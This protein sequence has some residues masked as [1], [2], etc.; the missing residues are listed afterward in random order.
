M[1]TN[2]LADLLTAGTRQCPRGHGAM[3]KEPGAWAIHQVT[4]ARDAKGIPAGVADTG[5][6]FAA[7]LFRCPLCKMLE[8]VDEGW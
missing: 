3:N 1:A 4:V 8:L 7:T 5:V 2:A 6:R